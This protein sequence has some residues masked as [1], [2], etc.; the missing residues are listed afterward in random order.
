MLLPNTSAYNQT[1][2]SYWSLQESS[3]SPSCFAQPQTAQQ[4]ANLITILT[5]HQAC[6]TTDFAIKCQTHAPA[7]G[8]AN[9]AGGV[10]I[11]ITGLDSLSVSEDHSIAYVGA[12]NSWLDVYAYLDPYHKSVAGG[13][14][15]AVG[16]GGLTIGG[17]ISYFSPQVGWTCDTVQNFE[18]VLAS[19]ELVNAN[20][21]S[22]PDLYRALKGGKNNFGLV[23]RFDFATVDITRILGGNL[24]NDIADRAAV[25]AAFAD[26]TT[27][28]H[29][30]VHA[31]WVLSTIFNA[32]SKAWTL[33]N[34]PVYTL[35]DIRPQVYEQLYAVPNISDT[36]AL[37]ELHVLANQ[38]ATPPLN[39]GMG[40]AT[41]GVST[42]FLNEMF[43][44]VNGTIYDFNLPGGVAWSIAF[45]PLPTV[46]LAPGAGK[47]V[48]GTTPADGN[49]MI[50]LTSPFW[51]D[52]S[53]DAEVH[54]K[55]TEIL[56]KVN[57]AAEKAGLLRQFEYANYADYSQQPFEGY[58]QSN[59]EFLLQTSKQYDPNGV[60]QKRVPGGF[61]L[62]GGQWW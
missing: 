7:A 5:S 58:G 21:S 3:L 61:K 20:A 24:A 44:I 15:G 60:F 54:A 33:L 42:A 38:T 55:T 17:G 52:S 9:I 19:G 31:S 36:L 12:G 8:F 30:D 45:E 28:P 59:V 49:Q 16:V 2:A 46:F 11:D 18:V 56:T 34:V 50:F 14:N 32:T 39:W 37:T 29:Y 51:T 4:A 40:T 25:F 48:L 57:A 47:N 27:A 13:R 1:Q 53:A 35:P 26:F 23:T 41:Y 10:T 43:D 62:P 6:S 22:N